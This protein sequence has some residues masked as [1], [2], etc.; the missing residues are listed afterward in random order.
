VWGSNL[1]SRV[2]PD[3]EAATIARINQVDAVYQVSVAGSIVILLIAGV[4]QR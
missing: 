2:R 4:L 1:L 3:Q